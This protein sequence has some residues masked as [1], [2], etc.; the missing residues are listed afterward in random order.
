MISFMISVVPP[1]I[2]WTR[3]SLQSPQSHRRSADYCSRRSRPGSQL[4]SAAAALA[5]CHLGGDHAP[6]D[7]LAAPQLPSRGVAPT[8]SLNQRLRISRPSTRTS[9]SVSSSRHSRHRSS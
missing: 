5:R 7:R 1:K 6:R 4:L 3:P 9:T 8:T 2:D